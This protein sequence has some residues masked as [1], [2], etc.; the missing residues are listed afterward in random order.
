MLDPDDIH[1]AAHIAGKVYD[2]GLHPA[3]QEAG[4]TLALLPQVVN[5]MLAPLQIWIAN[6]E[7]NVAETKKL[8]GAEAEQ[9]WSRA[10][11]YA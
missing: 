8:A 7:Y 4:K 2:D 9:G 1:E 11:C 10:Y 6:K 5:A 3:V